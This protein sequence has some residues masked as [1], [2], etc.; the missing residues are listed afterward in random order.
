MAEDGHVVVGAEGRARVG[1]D[2]GIRA[3]QH[4]RIFSPSPGGGTKSQGGGGG[5]ASGAQTPA[6]L[7]EPLG[8]DELLSGRAG[9]ISAA[10]AEESA[11]ARRLLGEVFLRAP[12]TL[13]R[14]PHVALAKKTQMMNGA[15]DSEP[16]TGGSDE[17]DGENGDPA[18]EGGNNAEDG[19][20]AGI[21]GQDVADV[22][23]AV[24]L[25][26]ARNAA[27]RADRER[28]ATAKLRRRGWRARA[29][30]KHPEVS[31]F[32]PLFSPPFCFSP[33]PS[34]PISRS[35]CVSSDTMRS[36]H[37]I[38][39]KKKKKKNRSATCGSASIP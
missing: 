36:H 23:I 16:Q 8:E 31:Q 1:S 38:I 2:G 24:S 11:A 14:R 25:Q 18:E 7:R 34:I 27:K 19:S 32:V 29:Y 5:S 15:A 21:S 10:A 13:R 12:E 30:E 28:S 39:F 26:Q 9:P 17:G 35:L 6:A 4:S 3:P 33:S 20:G 22:A 37:S